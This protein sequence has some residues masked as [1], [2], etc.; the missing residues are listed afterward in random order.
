METLSSLA[1][2]QSKCQFSSRLW[3]GHS[4]ERP[5]GG[6]ALE[7]PAVR[8]TLPDRSFRESLDAWVKD[9]GGFCPKPPAC[10]Q[11]GEQTPHVDPS[12][13]S[14]PFFL[15]PRWLWACL[16]LALIPQT[17]HPLPPPGARLFPSLLDPD[18]RAARGADGLPAPRLSPPT[19]CTLLPFSFLLCL[20]C[21]HVCC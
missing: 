2:H 1:G 20:V 14:T 17:P 18:P 4:A 16:C 21:T 3:S 15:W 10:L 6:L 5:P 11:R 12:P 13:T 8:V 7:E 19:P 9:L